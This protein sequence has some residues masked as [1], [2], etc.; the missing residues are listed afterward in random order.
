M[1]K[2]A[3]WFA[4]GFLLSIFQLPL[5]GFVQAAEPLRF[6]ANDISFLFPAPTDADDVANLISANDAFGDLE[7]LPQATFDA[8]IAAAGEVE[9]DGVKIEP[10]AGLTEAEFK[11]RKNWKVAGI[12]FDGDA[13]GSH[14]PI[15]QRTGS[16]PQIR[17]VLQPVTEKNGKVHVHDF[18]AHVA[19]DLVSNPDEVL[20]KPAKPKEEAFRKILDDLQKV[21][22]ESADSG[23][24]TDGKLKVHPGVRR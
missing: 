17:F 11:T 15:D 21:K 2:T 20:S 18:A 22:R 6:G 12:R 19:Y 16:R 14:L 24:A 13:S 3:G 8:V 5:A 10:G 4:I 7:L 1:I 9:V 23:V